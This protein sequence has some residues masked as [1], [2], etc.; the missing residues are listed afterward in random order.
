MSLGHE[1]YV[2]YMHVL[3]RCFCVTGVPPSKESLS[4]KRKSRASA[5][6]RSPML[7]M[8]WMATVHWVDY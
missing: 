4:I 3:Y 2:K 8:R 6:Q 5:S 1:T 7:D